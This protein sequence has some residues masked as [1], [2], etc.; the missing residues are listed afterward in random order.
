[1][2]D[3]THIEAFLACPTPDLWLENA[4]CNQTIMLIDH[5]N[6]E[7]KAASTALNLIYRYTDNFELLNK[8]S[9]IES[10]KKIYSVLDIE[11]K[12]HIHS[13]QILFN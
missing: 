1:M 3:I 10:T 7:K 12:E 9:K 2:T 11:L 8:L 13:I 4:L 6:C 5:A